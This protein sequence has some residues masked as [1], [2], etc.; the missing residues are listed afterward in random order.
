MASKIPA[1]SFASRVSTLPRRRTTSR[2]ARARITC[3]CR[4]TELV[5][6]RAPFGKSANDFALC[7]RNASRGSSR[8]SNAAMPSPSGKIVG[9]SFIEWTARSMRPSSSA[10]P[11]SLVKR[12]LPPASASERSWIRSPDVLSGHYFAVRARARQKRLDHIRLDMGK[13]GATRADT[14]LSGRMALRHGAVR[15]RGNAKLA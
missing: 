15:S 5:P 8:G 14:Q 3:A 1:S 2:S 12:P 13:F 7:E 11:S 9:T 10:S 4:R 6:I